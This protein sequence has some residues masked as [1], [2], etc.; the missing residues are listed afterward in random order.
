[1]IKLIMSDMDGT[2]LDAKGNVPAGFDNIIK[3]LSK[4]NV[5]FAPAS[6]RQYFS[7][8][9]SFKGY[10]DKFLFL[11]ENGTMVRYQGKELFS[12]PMQHDI[13]L[14]VIN[15]VLDI[16]QVYSVYCG[17]KNAYVLKGQYDDAFAAELAKYYSM[18]DLSIVT[19]KRE[20][21]SMPIAESLCCGTPAVG[22]KA[23]GPETIAIPDY[24][25][26][27]EY[28]DT[29]ALEQL[30]LTQMK[31]KTKTESI[32]AEAIEK[33]SKTKMTDEYIKLYRSLIKQKGINNDS[34]L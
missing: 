27:C 33:Y 28:G 11:A 21:F 20:T 25:A 5:I 26:F 3:E 34:L 17:K 8:L 12:S 9:D 1:M 2:L 16:P 10:E 7:L 23:G 30:V 13:A 18:A 22:F 6:G 29:D 24:C 15:T 31:T 19:G 14:N 32:S 4:R